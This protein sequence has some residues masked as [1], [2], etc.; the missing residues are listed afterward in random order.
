[1]KDPLP[2]RDAERYSA[3]EEEAWEKA[4]KLYESEMAAHMVKHSA[5]IVYNGIKIFSVTL[6]LEP[7]PDCLHLSMTQVIGPGQMGRMEDG[8]CKEI[9]TGIIGSGYEERSEGPFPNVRH[10]YKNLPESA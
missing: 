1:M 4:K 7:D 6:T 3:T 5:A 10:F 9:V 2:Q 8:V